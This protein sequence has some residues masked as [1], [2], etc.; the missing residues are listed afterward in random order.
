M[1]DRRTRLMVAAL[2]AAVSLSTFAFAQ[3]AGDPPPPPPPGGERGAME[4]TGRDGGGGGG[5][6]PP[7]PRRDRDRGGD[8][9][10]RPEG[11]R[12][13][14]GFGGGGGRGG[15][16]FQ[17]R[18][19]LIPLIFA[20]ADLN[21]SPTFNL[22]VE[23]EQKIQGIRD[24]F[25]QQLDE[26]RAEHAPEIADLR[27]RAGAMRGGGGGGGGG[28]R[29]QLMESVR[30]LMDTAPRGDAEAQQI[31]DVLTPEQV[32]QVEAKQKEHEE[33]RADAQQNRPQWQQDRGGK[34]DAK[35]DRPHRRRDARD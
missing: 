9:A 5:D 25:R 34:P 17:E 4:G 31:K 7:R 32:A 13:P 24:A 15:P 26:W 30:D 33:R 10:D 35:R 23:Q 20:L 29:R 3:D 19:A 21:L 6:R 16:L 14:G 22:S 1:T 2:S 12:G 8:S 11:R 28:D 18:N 27:Q